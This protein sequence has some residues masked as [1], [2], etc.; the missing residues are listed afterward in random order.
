MKSD[1]NRRLSRRV[2]PLLGLC[3]WVNGG[4]AMTLLVGCQRAAPKAVVLP[5]VV[6]AN[7]LGIGDVFSLV[8]VG[9]SN[10]PTGFTVAPDGTVD[11]PY[12]GR[13]KVLGLEPQQVTDLVRKRLM[14]SQILTNPSVSVEI[15][16]YNSK[17]VVIGGEV[18]TPGALP[19]EPGMTLV[20]ALSQAGGLTSIARKDGV[21]LRR[22]VGGKTKA[23]VV[24][25]DAI[26]NNQ[27]PDVPLQSGDTIFVPQR[28]F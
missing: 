15:K 14:D 23:V 20:R 21:V 11:V 4:S 12:I 26:I 2:S 5:P 27:I 18:R 22:A 3:L 8:I 10:L 13:I 25:Y 6:E 9:E 28:A 17:R 1:L 16:A 24:D 7:T 19:L